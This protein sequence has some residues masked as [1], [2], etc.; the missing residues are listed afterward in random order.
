MSIFTKK[1][2][3][4]DAEFQGFIFCIYERVLYNGSVGKPS[5]FTLEV[6][7]PHV[8]VHNQSIFTSEVVMETDNP[9]NH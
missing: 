8:T 4:L 1:D 3:F 2:H 6:F 7:M 5:I 9:P